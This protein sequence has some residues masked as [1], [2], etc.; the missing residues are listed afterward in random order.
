MSLSAPNAAPAV[1]ALLLRSL[2]SKP[3]RSAPRIGAISLFLISMACI[4]W[5]AGCGGGSSG[6]SNPPA[7]P[8]PSLSSLTPNTATAGGPALTVTVS[9]S[10]F[11]SSSTVQWNGSARPT[12]YVSA[13]G[14]NAAITAADI[15]T[16]GTASVTVSTPAP[17][18]GTS[19]PLTFTIDNPLPAIA[20]LTPN[21]VLAGTSAFTLTITGSNFVSTSTVQWNGSPR[22][23]TYVSSTV[24]Q[25]AIS[26][27]DIAT[28]GTVAVTVSNPTP[29]GG[30]S[31]PATFTIMPPPPTITL[32]T[33]SSAVAGGAAFTVVISGTK[34]EASS[35]VN[36][37]GSPRITTFISNT[38]LQAT[39]TAADIAVIGT[40][41][42][43]V[44][45]PLADGGSS[46][47]SA[48]FVGSSGGSNFAM[49]V[50]NQAA[51]DIV[52]DPVNNLFYLSVNASAST[53]PT[54]ICVLDPSTFTITSAIPLPAASSPN[55]LAISS[56]S[57]FLYAGLDGSGSVRRFALPGLANNLT[58]SLGANPSSATYLASDLQVA[59]GSP[60][61][62]AVALGSITPGIVSE[63]G[64]A[65]LTIFDDGTA[66]PT[67]VPGSLGT[68]NVFNT[69]Q[70]GSDATRLFAADTYDDNFYFYSIAVNT[71]GATLDHNFG[72]RF[73][74]FSPRI[75]FDSGTRLIYSDEGPSVDS[76]GVPSGAFASFALFDPFPTVMTPDSTIGTAF[77]AG[78][79]ERQFG[80]GP[81]QLTVQSF[82]LSH[83]SPISSIAL[84]SVP[85]NPTRLIRWAQNG[86]AFITDNG[87]VVLV[88]GNFISPAP[89]LTF[90]PPPIPVT[91][92]VPAPNA[93]TIST[94]LP[95]SAIAGGSGFTVTVTGSAF[96][97]A[98]TVQFDGTALPTTFVSSTKL[99]A[100]IA[101]SAIAVPGTA[102]VTVANPSSSGGVSA[103]STFFVGTTGGTS[104]GGS[105]FAVTVL[106][107]PAK[108]LKFDPVRNVIYLSVPGT[109]NNFANTIAVLDPVSATIVGEQFAGSEPNHLALSDDEQFLYASIDGSNSVQRFIL[110][111]LQPDLS[112][113]L[114][115]HPRWGPYYALDLQVAPRAPHTTAVSLGITPVSPLAQ[116]GVI[117]FDDTAP[118]S[119]TIPGFG[120]TT[121]LFDSLQWGSDATS[122]FAANLETTGDDFYTIAVTPGGASLTAD[123][124]DLVKNARIHFDSVTKLVYADNGQVVN[125]A[126]GTNAASFVNAA[127]SMV[128]DSTLNLAFFVN[129]SGTTAIIQSFNLTTRALV[130]SLTVPNVF[131][132]FPQHVIRWGQNGLAFT[133]DTGQ[134]YLVG[135]NFIH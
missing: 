107:Q 106:N 56:D 11:I 118:R 16:A 72:S 6:S 5:T 4:A 13:T 99:T 44:V 135:G 35:V 68:G 103:P 132:N 15:A 74:F 29:G 9:G 49:T 12:T 83:F 134:L 38:S 65:G 1:C 80:L 128:P 73:G 110:P 17:G 61:T 87:Q 109:A 48:F 112:Y 75:H 51:Q 130:D 116:G 97:P 63:P 84:P 41:K 2:R 58:I 32:M 18:G 8:T 45:N 81:I 26:A 95:S 57:Q 33:P 77:F 71:N 42:V 111:T 96:D 59:P 70:W 27:T 43:T 37:N 62:I 60:H 67:T 53:N 85:G 82:D 14:L 55:H 92:A 78:Q 100:T 125:P 121:N 23:T 31:A 104:Q 64:A 94:L 119:A 28:P 90:T 3:S 88:G 105:G 117:I 126:T 98:A 30:A 22:T 79:L 40:A 76:N 122:L 108:D 69:I 133:T 89:P 66:R 50:V 21:A 120:S 101:A 46:S 113:G 115:A 20:S 10:N 131:A 124:P 24:L 91:P 34:F 123:Y 54:T 127:S 86:L 114:G 93:P 52:F 102:S 25:A 19:S 47:P 36:W 129:T 7:N 39:F